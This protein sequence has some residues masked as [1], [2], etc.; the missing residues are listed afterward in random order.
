MPRVNG[1]S[2]GPTPR[3]AQESAFTGS[4]RKNDESPR[5]GGLSR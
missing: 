4:P 1:G 5:N 2:I 3:S